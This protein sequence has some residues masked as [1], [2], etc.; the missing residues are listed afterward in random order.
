[1]LSNGPGISMRVNQGGRSLEW[2]NLSIYMWNVVKFT[3]TC[4]NAISFLRYVIVNLMWAN[5][6]YTIVGTSMHFKMHFSDR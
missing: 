2:F 1:M 4:V 5:Y 6:M 3:L